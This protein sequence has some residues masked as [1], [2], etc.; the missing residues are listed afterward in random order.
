MTT[1]TP[2][3]PV[4]FPKPA[5]ATA[6]KQDFTLRNLTNESHFREL[7]KKK[8][9]LILGKVGFFDPIL[10]ELITIYKNET[11]HKP[12]TIR[13]LSELDNLLSKVEKEADT[14]CLIALVP[15]VETKDQLN[16]LISNALATDFPVWLVAL[17][18]QVHKQLLLSF[19]WFFIS[20]SPTYEIRILANITPISDED[21]EAL[22]KHND[23]FALFAADEKISNLG[24]SERLGTVLYVQKLR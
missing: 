23:I 20:S 9:I 5:I 15:T 21:I 8:N 7:L 13:T 12:I 16:R 18:S 11:G 22:N 17:P 10:T 14:K 4:S 19:N 3:K 1:T 6:S 2:D 24:I